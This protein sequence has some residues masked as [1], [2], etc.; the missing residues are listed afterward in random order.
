MDVNLLLG[1]LHLTDT[2]VGEWVNVMGYITVPSSKQDPRSEDE[3]ANVSV[4]AIVLWSAGSVTVDQ[5]EK[6]LV[7]LLRSN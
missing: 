1:T 5:Y 2:R 7:D 4:Q 3:Q 6:Y